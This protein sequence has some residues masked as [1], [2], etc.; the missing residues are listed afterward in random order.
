[1]S[2]IAFRKMMHPMAELVKRKWKTVRQMHQQR[3]WQGKITIKRLK[4]VATTF[5]AKNVQG[6]TFGVEIWKYGAINCILMNL[7]W[8]VP[9]TTPVTRNKQ[10]GARE[11]QAGK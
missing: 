11:A 9:I 2:S 10:T 3:L 8:V 5:K 7:A 1:M 4:N 6:R